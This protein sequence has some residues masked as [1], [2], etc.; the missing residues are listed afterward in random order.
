VVQWWASPV[1][2]TH[3]RFEIER[4]KQRLSVMLLLH[5]STTFDGYWT[6]FTRPKVWV[7]KIH[8]SIYASNTTPVKVDQQR[9]RNATLLQPYHNIAR[10][11]IS[12]HE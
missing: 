3:K 8:V 7:R 10:P 1:D 2:A 6:S 5:D 9:I 4:S 12:V 11:G